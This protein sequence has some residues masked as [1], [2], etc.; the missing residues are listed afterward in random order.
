MSSRGLSS[1]KSESASFGISGFTTGS[2][3]VVMSTT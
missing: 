1:A 2:V 3:G